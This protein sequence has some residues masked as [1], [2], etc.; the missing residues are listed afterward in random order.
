[1]KPEAS[2]ESYALADFLKKNCMTMMKNQKLKELGEIFGK[3]AEVIRFS[4][5]IKADL[6]SIYE[7][8]VYKL[9]LLFFNKQQNAIS[10]AVLEDFVE[11]Q[12]DYLKQTKKQLDDMTTEYDV[13]QMKVLQNE[14]KKEK[15]NLVKASK[16]NIIFFFL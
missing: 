14:N 15:V 6:V 7:N 2:N 4:E 9:I 12:Y 13:V 16:V 8:S 5:L 11:K 3:V 1:M 10:T